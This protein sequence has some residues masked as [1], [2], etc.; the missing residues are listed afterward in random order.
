M[1]FLFESGMRYQTEIEYTYRGTFRLRWKKFTAT[2]NPRE[3]LGAFFLN[4]DK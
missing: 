3:Q 4:F 1:I 2:L